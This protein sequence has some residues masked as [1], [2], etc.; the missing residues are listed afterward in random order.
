M[1]DGDVAR[2]SLLISGAL[3]GM[4]L[5]QHM[6]EYRVYLGEGVL[7]S[8]VGC[9]FM[10]LD[11]NLRSDDDVRIFCKAIDIALERISAY[12]PNVPKDLFYN[13]WT[14]VAY[15]ETRTAAIAKPLVALKEML[16][17][18]IGSDRPE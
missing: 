12:G 4:N 16:T 6:N 9:Y 7:Q 17:R 8:G 10:L 18:A 14:G 13:R 5:P 3:A 15:G 1:E 11:Q 2:S